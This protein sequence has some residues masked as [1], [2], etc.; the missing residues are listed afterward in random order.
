MADRSR[1][2]DMETAER[3][4]GDLSPAASP[5]GWIAP[6]DPLA[7]EHGEHVGK[8]KLRAWRGPGHIAGPASGAAG[9]RGPGHVATSQWT[10][11]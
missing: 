1:R 9:G 6:G 7:G 10:G 8:V 3:P 11:G 2:D 5:F 4:S